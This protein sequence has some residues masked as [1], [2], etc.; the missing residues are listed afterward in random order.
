MNQARDII[1]KPI[2]TEKSMGQMEDN[3]YTF[4]VSKKATKI[5]IKRAV[6]EIFKVK[7]IDVRT[8]IIKGKMKRLGRYQGRTSDWKKAIVTLQEG[9]TIEIFEGL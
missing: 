5:D 1:I 2:I 8:M 7:V 3:K 9:D 4:K 6:E